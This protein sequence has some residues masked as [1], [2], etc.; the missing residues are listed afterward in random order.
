VVPLCGV[1]LDVGGDGA[2]VEPFE[3]DKVVDDILGIQ[4]IG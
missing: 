2:R 3:Y 1:I 4:D